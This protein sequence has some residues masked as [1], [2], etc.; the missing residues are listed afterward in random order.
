MFETIASFR[1][2]YE[3]QITATQRL[4]NAL[5]DASLAQVVAEGYRTLGRIAWHLTTS[6]GDTMRRTGLEIAGPPVRAPVPAT[7]KEVADAY[8]TASLSTLSQVT[9][10]W[11]DETL[12]VVDDMYGE[13]WTRG[14]T[15]LAMI[16]HEA[17][18]RGQMTVLMRQAGCEVPDVVGPSKQ[19]WARWGMQPP[20][21]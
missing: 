15:L 20:A 9:G 18:H 11:N 21:V 16:V 13:P 1:G 5:T 19:S 8:A 12:R 6:V 14:Y 7:A 3:N 4:M 17:H 10:K 2:A